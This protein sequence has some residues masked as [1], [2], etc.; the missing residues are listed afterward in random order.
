MITKKATNINNYL[1]TWHLTES[2]RE[3]WSLIIEIYK[4]K[5][6]NGVILLPSYIGWSSN[7]GSGI[8][9]SVLNSEMSFDF[10]L[11]D[12]ELQIC[13]EDL[14]DKIKVHE[15]VL[16]LLVHYFGFYDK[17]YE[18]ISDYLLEK[19]IFF[20]EDCAH[21][22][23]TDLITGEC[24]RKGNYSFYSLHKL[25][26]LDKGGMLVNNYPENSDSDG[27]PFVELSYDF[28]SIYKKRRDNYNYLLEQ[29]KK[30]KGFKILH[31]DL[32][33]ICPQTLPIILD[34]FDRD[35]LYKTMNDRGFGL[36]SLYHTMI[37]ELQDSK[38]ELTNKV[39]KKISNFPV[40]QDVNFEDIQEMVTV[41]KSILYV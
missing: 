40:H 5:N 20:V 21:A 4:N 26:P 33:N 14:K 11:L 10:Y 35:V 18:N 17:N 39:S 32:G 24:G 30:M 7:E 34:D 9:D 6:P 16:V 2:A 19:K 3:A 8:F 12:S 28:L 38:Y 13:F 15:D 23:L 29:L 27:N 22:W 25:L 37:K 36:V 1:R 31:S 41:L